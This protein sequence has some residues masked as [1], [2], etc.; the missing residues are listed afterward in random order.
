ME[1]ALGVA[2]LE[3]HEQRARRRAEVV[4]RLT[5]G[6]SGLERYLQL[7]RPRPE[8]EHAFMFFPIVVQR[9]LRVT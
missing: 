1:A 9:C 7:P 8:A 5:E 2:Q 6:L 3:E 4:Q